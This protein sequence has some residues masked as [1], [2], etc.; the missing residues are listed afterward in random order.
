VDAG[1]KSHASS[2][3][4]HDERALVNWLQTPPGGYPEDLRPLRKLA[5]EVAQHHSD[6]IIRTQ[7][8]SSL[9][10]LSN[11]ERTYLFGE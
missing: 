2:L 3:P 1:V 8:L 7:G 10:R 6:E 4:T 9:D 11:A 5:I